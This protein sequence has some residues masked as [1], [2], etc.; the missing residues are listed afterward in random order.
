M[1]RRVMDPLDFG[2]LKVSLIF[3]SLVPMLAGRLAVTLAALNPGCWRHRSRRHPALG[4][5]IERLA[6]R[7]WPGW[8]TPF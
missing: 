3:A 1:D 2:R 6:H 4:F 5:M 7:P 8:P